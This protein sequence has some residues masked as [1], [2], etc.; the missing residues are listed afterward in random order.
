MRAIILNTLWI[1]L[2]KCCLAGAGIISAMYVA[3]Y[4]GP[5]K[6]GTL[7]YLN[8]I[9]AL[10][11]PFIQ[12]GSDNVLFNR[13]AKKPY[14]GMLLMRASLRLKLVLFLIYS[15]GLAFWAYHSLPMEHAKILFVLLVGTFFSLRD[16]YKLYY[17][18][19]LA[20][21]INLYI[22]N[23]ALVI[24]VITN[25]TLVWLHMDLVWFAAS[26]AVRNFIPYVIRKILFHQRQLTRGTSFKRKLKA[27]YN[28]FYNIYLIRV[29]LPLALSGLSIVIYTR[30]DQIL[31]AKFI[32]YHAVGLYGAA[33]ALGGGWALVPMA[34]ITS[35]MSTIA[36][37][38]DGERAAER[39]RLLYMLTI[40][41]CI[42]VIIILGFFSQEIIHLLYGAAFHDSASILLICALTSLCSILG[43]ISYRI[44]LLNSGYRF[45]AIKMPFIALLNIVLNYHFIPLYGIRGAALSTLISEATSLLVLNALFK[46]GLVTSQ[47]FSAYKSVP[48]FILGVKNYVKSTHQASL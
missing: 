22:N 33:M 39:A 3:R 16:I 12:L 18:A 41:L 5:E 9:I 36:S 28:R 47:L 14:S 38:R 2:E 48:I 1:I 15:V 26:L 32:G 19:T 44:I 42:P 13:I 27:K 4:L 7:S 43:T 6:F 29:G 31:L 34:L 17:D 37:E 8:S 25:L 40:M 20:S 35:F 11:L 24:F 10:I 46:K 23:S 45:V 30:V 21:K